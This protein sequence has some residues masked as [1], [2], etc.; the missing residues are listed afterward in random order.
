MARKTNLSFET[1]ALT[2]VG[3]VRK[4]NEDCVLA[5]D[6]REPNAFGAES[7]GI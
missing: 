5:L 1:A 3:R 6:G 7:Y 4:N 2:D